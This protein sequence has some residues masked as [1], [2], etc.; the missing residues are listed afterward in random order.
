MNGRL[1]LVWARIEAWAISIS[2]GLMM[3][4]PLLEIA[5]RRF[6]TG[7]SGSAEL[8]QHLVLFV[9]ML[10]GAIASRENRLLSLSTF[11][12][13]LT[14]SWAAIARGFSASFALFVTVVIGIGCFRFINTE[15][16]GDAVIFWGIP[17]WAVMAIMPI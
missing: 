12:A 4:L 3:V 1:C 6:N 2:L 16:I 13:F 17:G 11:T 7:I 15:G 14:G 8:L 5:L 9:A 10:G